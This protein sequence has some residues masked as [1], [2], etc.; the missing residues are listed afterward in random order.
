VSRIPVRVRL[1]LAFALAMAI[2]LAAVGALL[3]VRMD[4]WLEE[5][6]D[7]R[8]VARTRTLSRLASER[9]LVQ[10]DV[11]PGDDDIVAQLLSRDGS[12]LLASPTVL[13]AP[14]VSPG[15]VARAAEDRLF[16]DRTLRGTDGPEPGRLVVA[17]LDVDDGTGR[18][19]VIGA[20]LEDNRDA[21]AGLVSQFFV[22][23][24]IALAV[25]SLAGYLLAAAALRP[26]ERM[27]RRAAQIGGEDADARLPVPA[28]RDE[29][30][31]L[32]ETLNAMLARLEDGL[33][34][35]R[36]FVADASHELR[37]PLALLQTELEI[38]LRRE[39]PH[40]E[41]EDALRS[42]AEEVDRLARLAE[43][44]LVLARADAAGGLPVRPER[45]AV[46]EML[47]AV[48]GRFAAPAHAA[49]RVVR[50]ADGAVPEL[51]GDRLR[52]EQALGN[53]VHNALRHG[54]GDVCVEAWPSGDVVELRVRDEGAGFSD[55]IAA[56]AF[57][58]FSRGDEAR[59]S[60]GFG[61][62]LAIVDV[63]AR[64]HG[65][66]VTIGDGGDRTAVTLRLPAAAPAALP[67]ADR[68]AV[69]HEVARS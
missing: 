7:E 61:L 11:T 40:G 48:A 44:L 35:E 20:S 16:L 68:A 42:A 60:R 55:E 49:G 26:V 66:S 25:S 56:R 62:G 18:V 15:E 37:T 3:Q 23:G 2:V 33:A 67:P 43:D 14:L 69:H 32:G 10:S 1:T 52:L 28:A 5:Q 41:L 38:A 6:L 39:R 63:I 22:V 46:R 13:D 8:L 54:D 53:L 65:G 27:R 19:L 50:V 51:V 24:P 21:L 57:E 30:R 4:A 64:A 47:D 29:I 34:R 9:P 17:P 58:R 36:R 45:V 31:R 12:V 59:T